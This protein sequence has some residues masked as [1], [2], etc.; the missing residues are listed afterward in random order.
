MWRRQCGVRLGALLRALQLRHQASER[1]L[2][3]SDT[4]AAHSRAG[5]LVPSIADDWILLGETHIVPQLE[6]EEAHTALALPFGRGAEHTNQLP[7]SEAV[8]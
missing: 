2:G 1:G 7:V 6:T 5:V 8:R 3:H 4:V